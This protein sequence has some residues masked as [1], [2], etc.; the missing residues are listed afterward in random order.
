MLLSQ[1]TILVSQLTPQ[2]FYIAT[3][4]KYLNTNLKLP[5]LCLK[6]FKIPIIYR[7]HSHLL[8]IGYKVGI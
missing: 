8:G 1:T 6:A 7:K 4:V 2:K 3:T 5:L